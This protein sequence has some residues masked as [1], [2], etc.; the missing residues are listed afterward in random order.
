MTTMTTLTI[1]CTIVRRA[2][3]ASPFTGHQLCKTI[4]G[5]SL[6]SEWP[7]RGFC[8]VARLHSF[9]RRLVI[10]GTRLRMNLPWHIADN[11]QIIS[12]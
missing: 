9:P 3:L 5:R 10:L 8:R 4:S 11:P 12:C 2:G 7:R 1:G 6:K